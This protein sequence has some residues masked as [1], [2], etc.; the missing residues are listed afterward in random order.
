M[1]GWPTLSPCRY[2]STVKAGL[3]C[4]P[5]W[6]LNRL[7]QRMPHDGV[8]A[9]AGSAVSAPAMPTPLTRVSVAAAASTLLLMDMGVSSLGTP[10]PSP[11][12]GRVKLAPQHAP[13]SSPA[14]RHAA[15]S[16]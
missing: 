6:K 10:R 5:N 12:H 3:A 11:A 9:P 1:I 14:A 7:T 16:R 4:V 15:G 13:D 2:T 8:A